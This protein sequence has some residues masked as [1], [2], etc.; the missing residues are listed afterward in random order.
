MVLPSR[1]TLT[2]GVASVVVLSVPVFF[3][4]A[5]RAEERINWLKSNGSIA[6]NWP[7]RKSKPIAPSAVELTPTTQQISPPPLPT[8]PN[9]PPQAYRYRLAPG[10]RLVTSVFK[11]EGYEAQVQVLS[12]GTINLPR[13]GTVAVWGLTLEEARQRIT[14]GYSKFLRRPLVYLDLVEQRPVRV[15]VTGQVLRPGVFTLP[16]NSQGSIGISSDANQAGADGGGWPTM[17]DVIQKAG[18]IS[19]TGDLARLELL[20]PSPNPGGPT[21]SYIFDYLTVLKNGGF[22]PNPLIYD[23]DSIRVHKATSPENVNLLTTAASNFAPTTINVKVVGEVFSPGAVEIGSNSPLSSAI[24]AAGGVTRRGSIKRVDLIRTD[25]EG[26]SAVKQLRY[27]PSAVL[28]SENNPP[29]RNGD[30]VFVRRNTF[31]QVTDA[32]TDAT[33]PFEPVLDA[34]SVYRLLGLPAPTGNK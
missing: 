15:T 13:L 30:V 11:I 25:R 28:S 18:G 22:A 23:G 17:V 10:D 8:V 32:M 26:N 12:D 20:R 9:L 19:A 34:I 29:M 27:D 3:C 33:M 4:G 16:V 24:L 6:R 14:A 21:Q 31:T 7:T 5:L 2:A 1:T